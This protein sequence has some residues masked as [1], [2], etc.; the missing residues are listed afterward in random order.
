VYMHVCDF[1]PISEGV[2]R[3]HVLTNYMYVALNQV[4]K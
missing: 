3:H 4:T 2:M 1:P